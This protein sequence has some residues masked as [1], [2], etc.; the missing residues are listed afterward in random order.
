MDLETRIDKDQ[1]FIPYCISM[2][3]GR[4]FKSH[5][6]SDFTN[7]KE[8]L[9]VAINNLKQRKY[10]GYRV[11]FHNFSYFD[12]IFL[13]NIIIENFI[14]V[15]PMIRDHKLIDI[16]AKWLVHT[17]K[18]NVGKKPGLIDTTISPNKKVKYF[19]LHF[20]DSNLLL[21]SKLSKLAKNFKVENKGMFP[22]HFANKLD[23]GLD[24]EGPVPDLKYFVNTN[25]PENDYYNLINDYLSYRNEFLIKGKKWNL[26]TESIK[27]CELD[28]KILYEVIRKFSKQIFYHYNVDIIKSCTISSLAL[29]IY[30]TKLEE[31]LDEN[32]IPK[33]NTQIYND[34]RQ[35]Y[36]GG[37]VDAFIPYGQNI[38]Y[39]D[40]NSLYPFVMKKYP[41][42]V[43]A[44]LYFEGN[45]LDNNLHSHLISKVKTQT[46]LDKQYLNQPLNENNLIKI[47]YNRPFGFFE[48]EIEAPIDI[49]IPI[50]QLRMK[51]TKGFFRTISPLGKWTGWYFSED[52]IML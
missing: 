34:L 41:M 44:P 35:G 33:L 51:T 3:D 12:G 43:G 49:K 18:S 21:P 14:N 6:L 22:Y 20:R 5:Y 17:S 16:Q 52:Y 19:S 24:Y 7:S 40:V 50:L 47:D 15:K 30:K 46:L 23:I 42:P 31:L 13:L 8:M 25:L 2:Y 48:V 9:T 28:C 32:K 26:R 36:T 11:Y 38:Y 4:E 39:Y 29:R 37:S 27:Y 10:D 45:I 1:N